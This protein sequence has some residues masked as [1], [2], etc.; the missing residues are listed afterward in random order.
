MFITPGDLSDTR[1]CKQL[2]EGRVEVF[3]RQQQGAG[4]Q[5]AS[6]CMSKYYHEALR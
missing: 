1:K 2:F 3:Q 5:S 6:D 4:S